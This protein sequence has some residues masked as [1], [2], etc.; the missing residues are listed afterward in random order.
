M[1]KT[2][3]N[4]PCRGM[5]HAVALYRVDP[6]STSSSAYRLFEAVLYSR[7]QL[8]TIAIFVEYRLFQDLEQWTNFPRFF[9]NVQDDSC[10]V[11]NDWQLF[12]LA[13]QSRT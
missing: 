3:I 12:F 8:N 11:A 6:N 7:T 5:I 4:I 9:F 10:P 2:S 1:I 13:F